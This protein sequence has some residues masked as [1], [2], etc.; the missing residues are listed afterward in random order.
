MVASSVMSRLTLAA[1]ATSQ[2][3]GRGTRGEPPVRCDRATASRCGPRLPS[4]RDHRPDRG[5]HPPHRDEGKPEHQDAEA[6]HVGPPWLHP[7]DHRGEHRCEE[8]HGDGCNGSTTPRRP[9]TTPRTR[10][11][12]QWLP[13]QGAA[14][15]SRESGQSQEEQE[16]DWVAASSE[17]GREPPARCEHSGEPKRERRPQSPGASRGHQSDQR[18]PTNTNDAPRIAQSTIRT[19]RAT[20]RR[21]KSLPRLIP[22]RHAMCVLSPIE[23]CRRAC[24]SGVVCARITHMKATMTTS[25][26]IDVSRTRIT[27]SGLGGRGLHLPPPALG[28][29]P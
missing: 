15:R 26:T 22:Y 6:R 9:P 1:D 27:A 21:C 14:Y 7:L 24:S 19:A 5:Q 20:R 10:R 8:H 2:A 3:P 4:D 16:G 17:N 11:S 23:S 28:S 12:H 13:E 29:A 18:P 25:T